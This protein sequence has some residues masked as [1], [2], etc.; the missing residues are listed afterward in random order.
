MK[1]GMTYREFADI[2]KSAFV[3]VASDEYGIRGRPTNISRVSLLTGISRKEVKRQRE[4]L[5]QRHEQTASKTTDATRVLSGWHQDGDFL[6]ANGEP[7]ALPLEGDGA[8][9]AELCARY[10]GDIAV[11]TMYKELKRV[12]SI[13][14]DHD[15]SLKV[16]RRY[17]MPARLDPQWLM[18]VGSIFAD[19]GNNINHNLI[20]DEDNPTH[21]NGRATDDTIDASAIP[22]FREFVEEHGGPFL[23]R[24]DDWLTDHRANHDLATNQTSARRVRLGVGLYL[25]H[26][27]TVT[28]KGEKIG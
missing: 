10:A 4:L 25:I 2:S 26:G 12:G 21:F 28:D 17:Y 20:A 27:G 5:D 14:E 9:F 22:E 18:N 24:V 13:E 19:F 6:D 15:G 11:T 23:E 1:C 7:L 3:E 16:C 8:T